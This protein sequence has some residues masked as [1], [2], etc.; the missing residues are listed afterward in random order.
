MSAPI[1]EQVKLKP[2][3]NY[4]EHDLVPF[5]A[6]TG[7]EQ[8]K[9]ALVS[10]QGSGFTNGINPVAQVG[11]LAAGFDHG[12]VY[13]PLY[14][15]VAKVGLA[16][17]GTMPFGVLLFDVREAGFLNY[18]LRF[19]P[20]RRKELQCALSGEGVGILRAG[21]FT[22]SGIEGISAYGTG[23][24]TSNPTNSGVKVSDTVPGGWAVTT[25]TDSLSFGTIL[26][27]ADKEGFVVVDT[28]FRK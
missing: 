13:A 24:P 7:V 8:G 18:P 6:F 23:T 16:T 9:G 12:N 19:D 25:A 15:N 14:G 1:K 21:M 28:N 10:I 27:Q 5:F 11:N 4:N 17:S 2:F 22:V 20:T 3:Q 26:G